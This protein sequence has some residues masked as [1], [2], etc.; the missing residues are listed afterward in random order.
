[1]SKEK[2]L[3]KLN[4]YCKKTSCKDCPLVGVEW[5]H[6]TELS[7]CLDFCYADEQ[8]IDRALTLFGLEK[9]KP[10]LKLDYWSNICEMQKRQT[11][12]GIKT[13]GQP[14]ED[15]TSMTIFDRLEYLEEELIDGLMYIEHIKAKLYQ[16]KELLDEEAR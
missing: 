2:K 9:R 6:K 15:N 1:M 8:E 5:D 10:K 12:K 16:F 4:D 7:K 14:L 13:Y 11:E 3:E